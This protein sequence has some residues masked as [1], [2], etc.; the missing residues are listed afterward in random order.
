MITPE[1]KQLNPEVPLYFMRLWGGR[2]DQPGELPEN[3][4]DT[5][6]YFKDDALAIYGFAI[7]S[8]FEE[9]KPIEAEAWKYR[10][11]FL[12]QCY[13]IICPDGEMGFTCADEVKEITEEQFNEAK[14]HGWNPNGKSTPL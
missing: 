9:D 11:N 12:S 13:S 7:V 1:P 5:R 6:V 14:E 8:S 3:V 10:R 2:D 4:L